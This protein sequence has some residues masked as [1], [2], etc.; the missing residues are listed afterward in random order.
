[1]GVVKTKSTI[2]K[3]QSDCYEIRSKNLYIKCETSIRLRNKSNNDAGDDDDNDDE[4]RR[5]RVNW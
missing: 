1:M 2:D 5:G 3:I 4:D